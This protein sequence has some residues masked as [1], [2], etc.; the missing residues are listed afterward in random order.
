MSEGRLGARAVVVE[1][2][3]LGTTLLIDGERG[4]IEG[5]LPEPLLSRLLQ[6]ASVLMDRE[7]CRTL[8]YG[9]V[10]VFVDVLAPRPR[11]YIF[12]AVHI[13]QALTS[14]G[15]ALGYRVTVS[16]ARPAFLTPERFPEAEELL[17]GWP[18]QLT[19]RFS[20]D[21]RT[22]V[23][24]LSHDSR[25]EDPLWPLVL[26]AP[27]RYLGAMGSRK[28]AARRGERLREAGFTESQ[29]GSIHGPVGLDIGARTPEEV[30]VAI[31]AEMTTARY[32]HGDPLRLL[33]ELRPIR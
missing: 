17:V 13:G 32:R 25:F 19:D 8:S 1:G 2:E 33:G 12:G 4:L 28:T 5:R 30:A 10:S 24:V 14:L 23:V 16:D 22:F 29:I 26:P 15:S 11:L 31:L 20:F 7:E 18:D 21:S 9:D 3:P 27:T 6:D